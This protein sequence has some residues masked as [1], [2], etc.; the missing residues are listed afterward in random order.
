MKFISSREVRT[1]PA[2][3]WELPNGDETVITVN[4][5]PRALVVAVG[6]DL[7]AALTSVRRARAATA[8]EKIRLHARKDGHDT[9]S[10][11]EIDN[12][13]RIVRAGR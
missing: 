10:D 5:K 8:V 4:G 7:E 12:E 13:I 9:I 6:E 1:N 3:L 2:R 11:N